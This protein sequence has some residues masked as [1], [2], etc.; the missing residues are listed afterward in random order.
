MTTGVPNLFMI[1]F[2]LD[3]VYCQRVPL[4]LEQGWRTN[5]LSR[6]TLSATS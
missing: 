3:S 2:H 1:S 6:A 4:L 5:L